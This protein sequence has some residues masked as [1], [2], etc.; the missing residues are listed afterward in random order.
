M[1]Q[2]LK[3]FSGS[4]EKVSMDMVSGGSRLGI[5]GWKNACLLSVWLG[6]GAYWVG[7][8]STPGQARG[9]KRRSK[10]PHST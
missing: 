1:T 3:M 4:G 10:L 7:A 2:V 5:R 8:R 9:G 6:S